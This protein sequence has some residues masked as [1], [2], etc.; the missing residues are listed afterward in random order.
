ML[1]HCPVR[2]VVVLPVC[3]LVS[4]A[5]SWCSVTLPHGIS[6]VPAGTATRVDRLQEHMFGVTY[7]LY[8]MD[9][10][11]PK[12]R[13]TISYKKTTRQREPSVCACHLSAKHLVG[14]LF[15]S[16]VDSAF[17]ETE[18]CWHSG[19]FRKRFVIKCRH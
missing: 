14:A 1:L 15:H 19:L 17:V 13:K 4:A 9:T 8:D 3:A 2:I 12:K 6:S 10:D 16:D 18:T 7:N 11:E 5:Y